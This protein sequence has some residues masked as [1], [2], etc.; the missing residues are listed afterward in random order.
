MLKRMLF[1]TAA[2]G[3]SLSTP[4]AQTYKDVNGTVAPGFVPLIGCTAGAKCGGPV[5]LTNPLPVAVVSGGGGGG[6]VT[7]GTPAGAG[8]AWPF[9]PVVGGAAVSATNGVFVN[10]ATGATFPISGS[11]SITGPVNTVASNPTSIYATQQVCAITAAALATQTL[12]NGVVVKA[13]RSNAGTV[14]IGA[15]GVTTANGYPLVA[16]ESISYAVTNL[17]AIYLICQNNSD[18]IAVTGN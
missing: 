10:P 1:A 18:S 13:L 7:Q 4:W 2:L 5:S 17:S 6:A 12:T 9:Y 11:V 3:C 15:S 8:G 14:Y 16:G